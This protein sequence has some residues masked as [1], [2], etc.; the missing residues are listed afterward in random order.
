MVRPSY[1][2][3]GRAMEIVYNEIELNSY[4]TRAVQVN[5]EHPV[6]IDRYMIGREMEVDAICDGETVFIPGIMEHIEKAGVH[7]GDSIAVYPPQSVSK[8]LLDRLTATTLTITKALNVKGLL[9]LQFVINNGEVYVIEVNPRSSRTVPFLSKVTGV[10]MARIATRAIMGESLLKQGYFHG[11]LPPKDDIAVKV[12]VFSFAKLSDVE[13][14]LG[15]EMKST[16]EVMGKDKVFEKALHKA[17]VAAG[18]TVPDSGTILATISDQDKDEALKLF[19]RFH[20]V[21]FDFVATEGTAKLLNSAG[22]SVRTVARIGQAENDI[23]KEIKT[24]RVT[25]VIN[26]ISKG[27]NVESDG[28]K[29]RRVA[30]ERGLLCLTS[31]D[32]TEALLK[33]IERNTYTMEPLS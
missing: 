23:I 5:N 15:P 9:N 31:L 16:G 19:K 17:F 11:A 2:L 21:G 4:M 3:G 20:Q 29:M 33:T 10:P 1:V 18:M 32:T 8:D 22:I 26:T 12:P 25:L 14:A 13:I 27:K 6:L 28:F 7:S 30:V 24:G